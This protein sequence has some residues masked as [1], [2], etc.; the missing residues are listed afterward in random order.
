LITFDVLRFTS[1]VTIT[2]SPAS[3]TSDVGDIFT[4]DVVIQAGAQPVDT[5]EAYIYFPTGVL[6][7][8]DAG[9]NPATTVEGGTDFDMELT[10]SADNSAGKVHY[11]ATML[12]GSLSGDITVATIRFKAIGPTDEDWLR[13]QIWPP[14]KTDVTYLG[15]SVLTA[16][17]AAAVVVEG[18]APT[19]TPTGQIYLPLILKS[20]P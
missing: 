7:V 11:A 6:Q 18:Y 8:V 1:P 12:G 13:F 20:H 14:E 4:V 5:V 3:I 2:F 9:G 17:P 16:W 15:Q 10:N 19:P